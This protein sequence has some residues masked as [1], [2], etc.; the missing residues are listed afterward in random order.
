MK[1]IIVIALLTLLAIYTFAQTPSYVPTTGLV[2]WYDFKGNAN[3]G[4]SLGND[5]MIIP[6]YEPTLTSD[7]FGVA[8]SAYDFDGV[9]DYIWVSNAPFTAGVFTISV[10]IKIDDLAKSCVLGL[11]ETGTINAKKM[12]F[13]GSY[14]NT[15]K[16]S[17]GSSGMY[18][19]TA[20]NDANLVKI[21][22][23]VHIVVIFDITNANYKFY[24]NNIEYSCG[25]T[26][27]ESTLD[28]E[29][30]PLNNAGFNIGKHTGLSTK[31]MDGVIDDI[32]IWNRVLDTTE[33]KGLFYSS[34][35]AG[36]ESESATSISVYPNPA[37]DYINI[38]TE[39]IGDT[40]EIINS[41]GQVVSSGEI[42]DEN[43][44]IDVSDFTSGFYLVRVNE[45]VSKIYID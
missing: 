43:M 39:S 19:T 2:G 1:K 42:S 18:N 8:N 16:P 15:G 25:A 41:I 31:Y 6:G 37:T 28:G 32:G 14:N 38:K 9:N 10:W 17:I 24:I 36:F 34:I 45:I 13:A 30:F 33:I 22:E 4:S 3:D 35:N 11:G 29:I 26:T 5:G 44:R 40:Y 21:N 20:A 7:R 23:W 27:L 12:Y